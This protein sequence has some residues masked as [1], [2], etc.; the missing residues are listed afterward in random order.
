M[1]LGYLIVLVKLTKYENKSKG[2][3]SSTLCCIIL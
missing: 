2:F 1:S 3:M